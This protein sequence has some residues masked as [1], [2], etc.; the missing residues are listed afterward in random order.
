ML[1]AEDC[2]H[3]WSDQLFTFVH[4]FEDL[5]MQKGM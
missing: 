4:K 2:V 3:L 5:H 1:G